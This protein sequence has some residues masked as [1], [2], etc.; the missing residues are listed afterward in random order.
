MAYCK[1][2]EEWGRYLHPEV[3]I[4]QGPDHLLPKSFPQTPV[5]TNA[6]RLPL[7]D[8]LKLRMKERQGPR[9]DFN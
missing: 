3:L 5:S 1:S 4:A 6:A 8:I 2:R 9:M 7:Y